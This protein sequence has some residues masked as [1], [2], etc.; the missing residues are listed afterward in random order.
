MQT[1]GITAR[2]AA[3]APSA[4]ASPRS[5]PGPTASRSPPTTS[6]LKPGIV[7][8]EGFLVEPHDA[9]DGSLTK[10]DVI[11]I[12]AQSVVQANQTRAAIRLPLDE[13][14]RMV[15]AVT[16][17][18]GNVLGLYRMPG[19]TYFSID[20]S[21]AK[22]RNVA[23]YANPAELQQVDQLPGVPPRD[24]V[25]EPDD[26]LPRPAVL[27]GGPG[28]LSA[29]AVLDPQRRPDRRRQRPERGGRRCRPRPSRASTATTPSTRRRTSTTR[30]TS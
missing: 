26:P 19:A 3:A 7:V 13:S 17:N 24:G 29:R 8:P 25:H 30:T 6:T 27:P 21:V 2:T 16:D 18:D 5:T 20:V 12:T 1:L 14:S 22:A 4:A 23:Y 28:Q 15:I 11:R 10:D 9:A